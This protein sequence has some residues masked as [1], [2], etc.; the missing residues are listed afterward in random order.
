MLSHFSTVWLL[1]FTLLQQLVCLTSLLSDCSDI[2]CRHQLVLLDNLQDSLGDMLGS[3]ATIV[4]DPRSCC[5]RLRNEGSS[6][7]CHMH[8][9]SWKRVLAQAARQHENFVAYRCSVVPRAGM[10]LPVKVRRHWCFACLASAI[11]FEWSLT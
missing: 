6:S 5:Q 4:I 11:D 9:R 7:S 1:P 8:V 2:A 10:D 3:T